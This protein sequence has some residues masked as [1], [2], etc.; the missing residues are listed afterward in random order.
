MRGGGGV[1]QLCRDCNMNLKLNHKIPAIFHNLKNYYS[2]IIQE[3]GK[4]NLKK[5]VIPNA[6]K[7]H[8]SFT[9]NN[10]LSSIGS[11]QFLSSLLDS[12]VKNLK[13]ILSMSQE[14]DDVLDLAKQKGF[15]PFKYMNDIEKFKDLAK[16]SFIVC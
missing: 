12:S 14:F 13:M 10:K 16:K 9:I 2:H 1:F 7:K 8:M 6:L 5:N 4:F 3:L 11:L 15:Y